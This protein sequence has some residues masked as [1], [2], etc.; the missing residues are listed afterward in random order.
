[1]PA[2]FGGLLAKAKSM[3]PTKTPALAGPP[4]VEDVEEVEGMEDP[5]ITR[6]T[7]IAQ[8]LIDAIKGGDA[9][10]VAEAWMASHDAIGAGPSEA[11]SEEIE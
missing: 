7:P 5:M 6:L 4:E 2:D 10:G 11:E 3:S 1:M 9:Q 8:D